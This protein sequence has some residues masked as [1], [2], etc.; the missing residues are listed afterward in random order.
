MDKTTRTK[1]FTLIGL[2]VAILMFSSVMYSQ[3]PTIE[4]VK[5]TTSSFKGE[6][7]HD[8]D[9]KIPSGSSSYTYSATGAYL[10]LMDE[11]STELLLKK[12]SDNLADSCRSYVQNAFVTNVV[13]T[14][15]NIMRKGNWTPQIMKNVK[16]SC[17]LAQGLRNAD[18]GDKSKLGTYLST[19]D[20]YFQ[21][22]S[23]VASSNHYGGVEHAK[24]VISRSKQFLAEKSLKSCSSL[25]TSLSS[26]SSKLY[27]A[28]LAYVKN[29]HT[30]DACN[31]FV[32]MADIYGMSVQQAESA[33]S[34]VR[35]ALNSKKKEEVKASIASSLDEVDDD[36]W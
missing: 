27:A 23:V 17:L 19:V 29:A 35:E 28:H 1:V 8:T 34:S 16:E 21:A 2:L 30:E 33:I 36:N 25:I 6:V 26:A 14:S 5:L 31:D 32:G 15:S 4:D 13:N 9:E 24:S 22:L 18:K 20:K 3:I 12:I 10:Q 7:E 11:I